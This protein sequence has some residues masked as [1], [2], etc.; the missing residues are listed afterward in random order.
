MPGYD[1]FDSGGSNYNL[2]LDPMNCDPISG[3]P[4]HRAN[5]CQVKLVQTTADARL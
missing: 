3:T 2:T 4:E 5:L 1:P